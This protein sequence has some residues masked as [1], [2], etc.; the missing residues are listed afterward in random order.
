[1]IR[2]TLRTALL[3]S[4]AF[5]L[6]APAFAQASISVAPGFQ[7][8]V[9]ASGIPGSRHQVAAESGGTIWVGE[10]GLTPG[11]GPGAMHRVD[12]SGVVTP[13]VIPFLACPGQ[14][15]REPV[16]GLVHFLH[17]WTGALEHN[18]LARIEPAGTMSV[19][20]D[21]LWGIGHGLALDPAGVFHLG[22]STT[23]FGPATIYQIPNPPG[24]APEIPWDPG[25]A[26]NAFLAWGDGNSA[27][28]GSA[29]AGSG[30]VT[31]VEPGQ[32]QQLA[33]SYVPLT[34]QSVVETR[35]LMRNPF[36]AGWLASFVEADAATGIVTGSVHYFGPGGVFLLASATGLAGVGDFAIND[37]GA[38]GL[39]LVEAGAV[40]RITGAPPPFAPGTLQ[41]PT[42]ATQG[43]PIAVTVSGR[44]LSI[45]PFVL[46]VDLPLGPPLF[47]L[48]VLPI[49]PYG[50]AHTSLGLLPTF[51]ALEDG[52][53]VFAPF[54]T[55]LG[56]LPPQGQRTLSYV[57]PT[58]PAPL[59]VVL[60]AYILDPL[61]PNGLFWITN[62][63][64]LALS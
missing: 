63:V 16:S 50:V 30:T 40:H 34:A 32:A 42:T 43:S 15:Q 49:P 47:P 55:P 39:L 41:A 13:N 10:E 24:S 59:T 53:P 64:F 48:G 6:A 1:M 11:F 51:V 17:H 27:L 9:V 20:I 25:V 38:G 22:T 5:A 26:D 45:A 8:A 56:F 29:L 35:G 62:P 31:R 12:V 33:F 18:H 61:A 44:P 14:M 2:A 58:I 3:A 37:D 54:P 28:V 21:V 36:G 46:A 19:L 52:I 23:I 7:T 60:Q 57:V 4:A